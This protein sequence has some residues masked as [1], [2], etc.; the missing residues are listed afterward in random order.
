[1]Y[2]FFYS[3]WPFRQQP[4]I[5]YAVTPALHNCNAIE[6][7]A[8]KLSA[9]ISG[10]L[11]ADWLRRRENLGAY[12][13]EREPIV[14]IQLRVL[15]YLIER[16]RD[17]AAALLP[18]PA[19]LDSVFLNQRAIIVNHHRS[20][21]LVAGV[22][23]TFEATS[24][25]ASILARMNDPLRAPEAEVDL[26]RPAIP[27]DPWFDW[28]EPNERTI[29]EFW[30][31]T[32]GTGPRGLLSRAKTLKSVMQRMPYLPKATVHELYQRVVR[33]EGQQGRAAEFLSMCRN[34]LALGYIAHA[35]RLRIAAQQYDSV[36]ASLRQALVNWDRR[37]A[38]T[39][40]CLLGDENAEVRIAAAA[41]LAEIGELRDV[42]IF[43]DL[44]AMP[45]LSDEQPAER[46][47]LVD[48][49]EKLATRLNE[50]RSALN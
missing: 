38:D 26:D 44:L 2:G 33:A 11:Y 3:G 47:V 23:S 37:A 28:D 19:P 14:A 22:K 1:M 39:I 34:R 45:P 7:C 50:R 18:A 13:G 9:I 21:G 20:L 36:T 42:G 41:L 46:P 43:A 16:Y 12:R 5:I 10:T 27:D 30:F 8:M 48:S 6:P 49:M 31:N 17:D 35:W 15:D 4:A 25:M 40:R 29:K 32:L 24:R